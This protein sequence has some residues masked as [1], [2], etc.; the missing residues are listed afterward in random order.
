MIDSLGDVA[1]AL[2]RA[3]PPRLQKLYETLRLEMTY[4][5]DTRTVNVT[6]QPARRGSARVRG[7]TCTLTTRLALGS[8]VVRNVV[9][10]HP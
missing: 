6:I 8:S 9:A 1:H 2:N 3:D 4:N 5:A 7:G 10:F